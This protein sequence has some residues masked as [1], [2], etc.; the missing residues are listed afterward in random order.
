MV[1]EQIE[2]LIIACLV[3]EQHNYLLPYR[4]SY[5]NYKIPYNLENEKRLM[6]EKYIT[7]ET[8]EQLV[9]LLAAQFKIRLFV[10]S[11]TNK[12]VSR[13]NGPEL[14]V[15]ENEHVFMFHSN[16][17]KITHLP[18]GV[19]KTKRCFHR[20]DDIINSVSKS[21]IKFKFC[22]LD[23]NTNFDKLEKKYKIGFEIW[24]KKDSGKNVKFKK[25][26]SSLTNNKTV[27][28]HRDFLT[29][30][31]FLIQDIK[32]YFRGYIRKVKHLW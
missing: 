18:P 27:K 32:L 26:R 2:K 22:P 16:A 7:I 30:K 23:I 11:Y 28:L 21:T 17:G 1:N 10:C 29:D 5:I 15:R 24:Q 14:F 31:L 3:F 13:K 20:L 19:S 8:L 25:Y 4:E 6:I 9:I 12:Y